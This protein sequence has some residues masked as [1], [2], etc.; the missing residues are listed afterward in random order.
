MSHRH[1]NLIRLAF[2]ASTFLLSLSSPSQSV[3]TPPNVTEYG[4]IT[5][6]FG[7]GH[8]Y[9]GLVGETVDPATG[10]VSLRIGM[11]L[12]KDRGLSLNFGLHYD[13]ASVYQLTLNPQNPLNVVDD[14]V[15]FGKPSWN[16]T[17]VLFPLILG[18]W[19]EG[20]PLGTTSNN[21]Y[22]DPTSGFSCM[23]SGNASFTD[24]D[25][26]SHWLG[27]T[28]TTDP[29]N[30][31]VAYCQQQSNAVL[32]VSADQVAEA[33]F[34]PASLTVAT[35]D[36]TV[37]QFPAT[38]PNLTESWTMGTFGFLPQ[39]VEDRNGNILT[40]TPQGSNGLQVTD[41]VGRP[42][43][44]ETLNIQNSGQ[45]LTTNYAVEGTPQ[46]YVAT[47]TGI[48]GN[49]FTVPFTVVQSTALQG[50]C[51]YQ[52]PSGGGGYNITSLALPDGTSYQFSYDPSF[53]LLNQIT[54]P[55]GAWV[56]YT[57]SIPGQNDDASYSWI[58]L[59]YDPTGTIGSYTVNTC[60]VTYGR[61]AIQTRTVS[62]DGQNV[63]LKETYSYSTNFVAA[64]SWNFNG[65]NYST[66]TT[67]VVTQDILRNTSYSTTYTYVPNSIGYITQPAP[68][69]NYGVPVYANMSDWPAVEKS[70][71]TQDISGNVLLT[72]NKTW[73]DP[74]HILTDQR[75]LPSG[76]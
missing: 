45:Q 35:L 42:V 30:G 5:P 16:P 59:S 57:W 8:D 52:G 72:E 40:F 41:T 20:Y 18:G 2:A 54:Y 64:S 69:S 27:M 23:Y 6:T 22:T 24:V 70:V 53:G 55:N 68:L 32:G 28:Y 43:L 47:W 50:Y 38:A 60:G 12:P 33:V 25:G 31:G 4:T 46:P 17:G 61:P 67:N 26:S 51:A 29:G 3:Q 73:Q 56:K 36:G 21:S 58:N 7:A 37:Y 39:T 49:L 62:F 34:D 15:E 63:A 14:P 74:A 19:A 71:Q 48:G 66:K 9:L 13:S 75:V 11:P 1:K 65:G 10:N 44:T 76:S